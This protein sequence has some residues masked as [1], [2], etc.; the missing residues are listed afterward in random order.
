MKSISRIFSATLPWQRFV[1]FAFACR[2]DCVLTSSSRM[3]PPKA[4]CTGQ[5]HLLYQQP[6]FP[7]FSSY[8][9]QVRWQ[10]QWIFRQYFAWAAGNK[11]LET[12]QKFRP[13]FFSHRGKLDDRTAACQRNWRTENACLADNSGMEKPIHHQG[14][15]QEL[16]HYSGIKT[17]VSNLQNHATIKNP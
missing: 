6:P 17:P 15:T 10:I 13:P 11:V 9:N 12:I 16:L 3:F 7:L 1:S 5:Q 14:P 4:F 8:S 2:S